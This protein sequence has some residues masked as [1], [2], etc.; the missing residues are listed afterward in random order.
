MVQRTF[1]EKI[2]DEFVPVSTYDGDLMCALPPGNHLITI[3]SGFTK[4]VQNVD[5]NFVAVTAVLNIFKQQVVE[6]IMHAIEAR[7]TQQP[8][9]TAQL[10][11]RKKMKSAFGDDLYCL[12][13]PSANDCAEAGI[14]AVIQQHV[15]K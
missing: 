9:T 13:Y 12:H 2:N 11:A 7:S 5:P 6:E 14:D 10:A 3:D 4:R 8:L 1:Y 15:K